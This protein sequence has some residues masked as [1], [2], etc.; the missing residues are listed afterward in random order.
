[1]LMVEEEFFR[2]GLQL[3]TRI[4][5]ALNEHD[6]TQNLQKVQFDLSPDLYSLNQTQRQLYQTKMQASYKKV[7]TLMIK[8]SAIMSRKYT[9]FL[10]DFKLS[11]GTVDI[12]LWTVLFSDSNSYPLT[13]NGET[14]KQSFY[15]PPT[16]FKELPQANNGSG[17][18]LVTYS[19]VDWKL[20]ILTVEPD[21]LRQLRGETSSLNVFLGD[22]PVKIEGLNKSRIIFSLNDKVLRKVGYFS[23]RT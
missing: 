11:L 16:L 2:T 19:R 1:M 15:L 5:E 10:S 9:R 17:Y 18:S 7:K 8:I 3:T 6:R 21:T 20:S 23:A 4:F 22:K 13:L 12:K 14:G